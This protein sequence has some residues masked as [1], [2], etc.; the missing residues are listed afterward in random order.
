MD[1]KVPKGKAGR[2]QSYC[3]DGPEQVQTRVLK[4]QYS[5]GKGPRVAAEATM[6]ARTGRF[7][8]LTE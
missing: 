2:E 5:W 1:V 3:K 7:F 4:A 8:F 6:G